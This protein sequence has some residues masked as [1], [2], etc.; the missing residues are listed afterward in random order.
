MESA[1]Q[2]TDSSSFRDLPSVDQL[3]KSEAAEEFAARFGRESAAEAARSAIADL[4]EELQRNDNRADDRDD[5]LRAAEARIEEALRK[6]VRSGLSRVI[7]A[8][9]VI[10]HTNLGRS[11]L[12]ERA[13]DAIRDAAGYCALEYDLETGNRG[14]RGS[15]AESLAA[16]LTGAED[17]LIVNNCA[18]AA[19]LVLSS[20][21]DG[22]EAI[23]SRGELVEIG[24][25]FRVPDV[26][27]RSGARLVEVGT[28]NRTKIA[29]YEKAVSEDTRLLVKVHPSNYRIVGFT[30]APS[31][32]ELA[33]LAHSKGILFY[34]DA[35]SGALVDLSGFGM[36][37]EPV[38]RTSVSEGADVVTFS[39]DKLLGSIQSGF[40]VGKAEVIQ[41][42]RSNPLYRALRPSKI[43]YAA[44]E[45]TL[46]AFRRGKM[47]EEIPVL[48]MLARS[49][50]EIEE[51][52][53]SFAGGLGDRTSNIVGAKV[54]VVD[55]SSVVGGGSAPNAH[56][57][58]KL[59]SLSHA[60]VGANEIERR[61]RNNEPPVIARI[62]DDKV[63]LD[64]RTVDESDLEELSNAVVAALS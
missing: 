1:E 35:G 49:L 6:E 10:I 2:K 29:D 34:E 25:D 30:S 47:F 17:A 51:S 12:S 3:L 56:Q 8:T 26:M 28:T 16:E 52:T 54:A 24:G 44:L 7:N 41:S 38:I 39:G 40:V 58:G 64:L 50:D 59:I 13:L 36:D 15:R 9:G 48:K 14:R 55:G 27:E 5:L 18:A 57:P 21:C 23:V 61:L 11:P 22:G 31:V 53:V 19:V 20:L 45:A 4:R 46:G 32:R 60:S 42:I 43:I 33:E 63:V 62:E 37:D